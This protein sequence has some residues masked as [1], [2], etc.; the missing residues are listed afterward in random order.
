MGYRQ[1]KYKYADDFV[2]FC[3]DCDVNYAKLL[4][5][6]GEH[7]LPR[8]YGMENQLELEISL[9]A[10]HKYTTSYRLTVYMPMGETMQLEHK[11]DVNLY[12][13][14]RVAEVVCFD[15]LSRL[16][17]KYQYPNDDMFHPDE[18]TQQN[19]LLGEWLSHCA[20]HGYSKSYNPAFNAQ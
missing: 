16:S 20:K 10:E 11:M 3:N 1:T 12:H 14:A 7:S 17:P 13:D 18:K 6:V 2:K 19:R 4:R 15:N 8:I 9:I 5:L